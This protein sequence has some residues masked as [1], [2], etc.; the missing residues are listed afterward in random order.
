M[1]LQT[2]LQEINAQIEQKRQEELVSFY[3]EQIPLLTLR[4]EYEELQTT[5]QELQTRR[6]YAQTQLAQLLYKDKTNEDGT[7]KSSE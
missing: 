5:I 7:S 3:K 1:Q 2:Q 4:K 6:T